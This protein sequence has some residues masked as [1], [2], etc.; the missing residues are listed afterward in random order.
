MGKRSEFERN[1][2]DFYETPYA[3]AVPVIEHLD[4]L[5][6]YAEVCAGN[7]LLCYHLIYNGLEVAHAS[8]IKPTD[9]RVTKIDALK[10]TAKMLQG[11]THIITN[12]P[13]EKRP[14]KGEIFNHIMRHLLSIFA[15]EIWVLLD[16]DYLHTVQANEFKKYCVKVVSVGRVKWIPGSKNTGKDNCAWYCFKR[17]HQGGTKFVW[18]QG[19]G[20]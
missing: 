11:C 17:G 9:P 2:R 16:A 4:P 6:K 13:W 7:F 5:G 18:R 8:D 14:D 15:G 12:P 10:L 19:D 3:A 20:S 1:P